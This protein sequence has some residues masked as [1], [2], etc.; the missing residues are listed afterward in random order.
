MYCSKSAEYFLTAE[1]KVV[2][3]YSNNDTGFY[4]GDLTLT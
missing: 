1:L 3:I 4:K 2:Y